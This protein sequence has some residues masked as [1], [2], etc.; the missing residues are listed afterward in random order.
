MKIE[1]EITINYRHKLTIDC[2]GCDHFKDKI[3]VT[4]K[5]PIIGSALFQKL[6]GGTVSIGKSHFEF[7]CD[8]LNVPI[9][10]KQ[11][12]LYDMKPEECPCKFE[13]WKQTNDAISEFIEVPTYQ[14]SLSSTGELLTL[15]VKDKSLLVTQ[16]ETEQSKP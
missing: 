9:S 1:T 5:Y 13:H 16:Q 8:K 11:A 7:Y 6:T 4:A 14:F 10:N 15:E 2:F 12:Y 3:V